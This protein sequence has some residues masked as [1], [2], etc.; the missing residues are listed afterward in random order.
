MKV[1]ERTL[2]LL[3]QHGFQW[4]KSQTTDRVEAKCIEDIVPAAG[5]F[6]VIYNENSVF[7][8]S[9]ATVEDIDIPENPDKQ[10]IR[11]HWNVIADQKREG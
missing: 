2:A 4:Y 10:W 8:M 3:K 7:D 11:V 5:G 9:T 1:P 6:T